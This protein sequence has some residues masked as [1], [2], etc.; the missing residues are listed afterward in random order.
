M[1]DLSR[2]RLFSRAKIDTGSVRL[3][4]ITR[5]DEF[6]YDCTRCGKCAESCETKIIVSG[7]GGFPKVDFE[8]DECTFCYKCADACP[9]SIFK[10]ESDEPWQATIAIEDK[11]LAY[12][13][14]ECRSCSEICEAMVISF[15]PELGRVAQ[16]KLDL[17]MC[18]G[19]GACVSVCPTS[20]IKVSN[21][22]N[23]E[24]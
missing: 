14:I 1:V 13:N 8:I 10:P 7:D 2:R 24:R 3:P 9:E 4:W 11:C 6:V 18:N 16:P 15:K 23:N 17:D 5:P 19:C 20:A 12:Q 21:V 22:N